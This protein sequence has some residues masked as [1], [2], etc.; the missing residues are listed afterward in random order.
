MGIST[1]RAIAGSVASLAVALTPCVAF[2]QDEAQRVQQLERKL[3]ESLRLIDQL[4]RRLE[5][6]EKAKPA[7]AVTPASGPA[8][9]SASAAAPATEAR[10]E[11]LEKTVT[12]MAS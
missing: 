3:E 7:S 11:A 8:S 9:A 12:Q 10:I 1:K 6:L 5:A 2:A 4:N